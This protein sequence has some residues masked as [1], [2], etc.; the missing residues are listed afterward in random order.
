MSMKIYC[1]GS[2]IGNPGIGG[3]AAI[4]VD[5]DNIIKKIY[6]FSHYTT[7]NRMELTAAIKALEKLE[8]N[9]SVQIYTDSQYLKIGITL[10]IQSWKVT[11]WKNGKIK[12]IKF[13]Q[14]LDTL[15][16]LQKNM[17]WHWIKGHSG[18]KYNEL[19]DQLAKNAAI[20]KITL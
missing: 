17:R 11:N 20:K 13:W 6:G 9:Q 19:S 3:W 8:T 4:F 7:N 1:D 15:Y 18:D 2:C 14:R 5:N 16:S 12:N 10:W